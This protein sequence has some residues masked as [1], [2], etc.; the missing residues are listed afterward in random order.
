MSYS[1]QRAAQT[2]AFFISRAGG[3]IEI[4]KLMKLMYLAE[5]ESLARYGEPI[6]GDVLVSMK[7]G[8]VLSRTLDHINGFIDSEEGGWESWVSAK[9]GLQLGLQPA[10]DPA[11]LT[12]LS[13]ADME[14][15]DFIWDKFGQYSK[16]KLRDVTH[17]ICQEWEDP[18]DTSQLIPYSR[19]LNCVGYKPEVVRELEQR[20]QDEEELGKMFS[21]A[22]GDRPNDFPDG[23]YSAI[24]Q[25]WCS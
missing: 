22:P 17:K 24:S 10:H 12:Q 11:Q 9:A 8:P 21:L 20:I 14:I 4:L 2:A 3:T 16:Y 25:Q 6:I 19:V 18:G 5:R 1:E 7:H 23:N 15:L 13:D